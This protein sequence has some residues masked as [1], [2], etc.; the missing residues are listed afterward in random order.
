MCIVILFVTKCFGKTNEKRQKKFQRYKRI[1]IF[2]LLEK[3]TQAGF[4]TSFNV[5][6]PNIKKAFTYDG[7]DSAL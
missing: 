5:G 2:C 1:M 7:Y 4:T 6:F 3:T